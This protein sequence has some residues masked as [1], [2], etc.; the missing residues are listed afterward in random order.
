MG[1]VIV[2]GANGFIGRYVTEG[3][4]N[5]SYTVFAVD[6]CSYEWKINSI[7]QIVSKISSGGAVK[8]CVDK[9]GYADVM[10][11]LA[12]DIAVPGDA[13][14]DRQPARIDRCVLRADAGVL[15]FRSAGVHLQFLPEDRG[16][17]EGIWPRT[18]EHQV[19]G[20]GCPGSHWRASWYLCSARTSSTICF[21][22]YRS[23]SATLQTPHSAG[24][25][26]VTGS[27]PAA[28]ACSAFSAD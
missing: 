7:N 8:N 15:Q 11:H 16:S 9:I 14:A 13:V 3:L 10:V 2:T 1:R 17:Q 20:C 22:A 4:H 23:F 24:I 6:C 5:A 27:T 21:R 12:A 18:A 28:I 19:T 25:Q 26:L